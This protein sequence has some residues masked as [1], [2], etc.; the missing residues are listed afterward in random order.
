MYSSDPGYY[1]YRLAMYK[2]KQM[3]LSSHV[4][5]GLNEIIHVKF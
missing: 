1:I 2:A 4:H 5:E 3:H